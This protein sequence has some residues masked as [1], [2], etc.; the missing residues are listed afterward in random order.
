MNENDID[1]CI[2]TLD[3]SFVITGA[4]ASPTLDARNRN[5]ARSPL[6]FSYRVLP[7]EISNGNSAEYPSPA[8]EI[9]TKIIYLL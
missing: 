8:I 2:L 4:E 6:P 5:V 3:E 7:E 9:K 1:S